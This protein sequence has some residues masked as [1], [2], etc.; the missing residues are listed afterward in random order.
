MPKQLHL[1]TAKG[2]IQMVLNMDYIDQ[3]RAM[4]ITE[5][6]WD[7]LVGSKPWKGQQRPII[8][9][10]LDNLLYG[11]CDSMGIVRFALPAEFAAGVIVSFVNPCNYFAACSWLGNFH[12]ADELGDYDG[13]SQGPTQGLEKVSASQLFALVCSLRT[14]EEIGTIAQR[15]CDKTELTI[16]LMKGQLDDETQ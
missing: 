2:A 6:E 5:K 9:R 13:S 14:N 16:G 12:R 4:G 8:K 15:F 10:L 1:A 7:D 3:C 11:M